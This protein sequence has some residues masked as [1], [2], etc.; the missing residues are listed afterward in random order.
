MPNEIYYDNWGFQCSADGA[1]LNTRYNID[2]EKEYRLAEEEERASS[3]RGP[4]NNNGGGRLVRR[5]SNR[6]DEYDDDYD[7]EYDDDIQTSYSRRGGNRQ[8]S[9]VNRRSASATNQRRPAAR[10]ATANFDLE[11][12][13]PARG[14][15]KVDYDEDIYE[16]QPVKKR[17]VERQEPVNEEIKHYEFVKPV[18][19]NYHDVLL[20]IGY[21]QKKINLPAVPLEG[22]KY[23]VYYKREIYEKVENMELDGNNNG[24]AFAE[25]MFNK[26]GF[27]PLSL[28]VGDLIQLGDN[29]NAIVIDRG[30]DVIDQLLC[31]INTSLK[32]RKE[33]EIYYADTYIVSRYFNN[34]GKNLFLELVDN[35][36]FRFSNVKDIMKRLEEIYAKYAAN[37]NTLNG[38]SKIDKDLTEA[39]NAYVSAYS[40]STKVPL[41]SLLQYST[42][43][44]KYITTTSD[45][46]DSD[47]R[48]NMLNGMSAF[49]N[50]F[51][52]NLTN[53][54]KDFKD[55]DNSELICPTR[56][57]VVISENKDLL[58]EVQTVEGNA[59]GQ[60]IFYMI[61]RTYSP[62][63]HDMLS[64]L[65][66]DKTL[67]K[68]N[69]VVFY[70]YKN[71]YTIIKCE[72]GKFTLSNF[73]K[74]S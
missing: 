36:A 25:D 13:R 47:L 40:A 66:K 4:V 1:V 18:D 14:R 73:E 59:A 50:V 44:Y 65:D 61:D 37:K 7:Y 33:D 9:S 52:S 21:E 38:I 55:V 22:D 74:R 12:E 2:L 28:D 39:F 11:E 15:G 63:L 71:I 62:Y 41:Y 48:K 69:R 53:Y 70:N 34:T 35:E 45:I 19:G 43:W 58:K 57:L 20:P 64:R 16:E 8:E 31:L 49:F 17:R 27:A 26:A 32:D 67:Q 24:T 42:E 60:N 46:A 56:D 68:F 72:E 51:V 10:K 54:I 29:D 3:R 30:S 5:S 6:R 23:V